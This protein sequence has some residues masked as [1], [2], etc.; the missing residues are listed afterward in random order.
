VFFHEANKLDIPEINVR[1]ILSALCK[2]DLIFYAYSQ[3][4]NVREH[5]KIHQV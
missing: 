2:K 3:N 5:E 4:L 1:P